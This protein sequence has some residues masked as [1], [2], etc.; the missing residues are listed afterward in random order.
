MPNRRFEM[1]QYRHILVRMRM[2]DSN[3]AIADSGVAGRNKVKAIK[4]IALEHGWLELDKD[5]PDDTQLAAIFG[6]KP[7]NPTTTSSVAPY[8]DK[9][10]KWYQDGVQGTTIHQALVDK[11]GFTGSHW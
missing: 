7:P 3:R 1:Y 5:L 10:D 4:R 6:E 9:V 2:G 11:Y 8:A